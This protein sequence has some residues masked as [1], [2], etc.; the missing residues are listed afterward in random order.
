MM[1]QT[2]P[3]TCTYFS[4]RR[5]SLDC[6][7]WLQWCGPKHHFQKDVSSIVFYVCVLPCFWSV[8][9]CLGGLGKL[10]FTFAPFFPSPVVDGS[11][12]PVPVLVVIQLCAVRGGDGMVAIGL[13]I[14][15]RTLLWDGRRKGG[16]FQLY[17]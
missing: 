1:L 15:T 13:V 7:F 12:T 5:L 2:G 9:V 4:T 3:R 10:D 14:V 11:E 16:G 17:P 6:R 8:L